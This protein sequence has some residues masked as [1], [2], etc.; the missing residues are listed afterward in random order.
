MLGVLPSSAAAPSYCKIQ[1]Q[2][3]V[4]RNACQTL[5]SLVRSLNQSG[6]KQQVASSKSKTL[7]WN[8]ESGQKIQRSSESS[9]LY[10]TYIHILPGKPQSR[11]RTRSHRGSRLAWTAASLHLAAAAAAASA[12]PRRRGGGDADA[13]DASP[14]RSLT[15]S[16]SWSSSSSS[17]KSPRSIRV[18]TILGEENENLGQRDDH[19]LAGRS[20]RAIEKDTILFYSQM[21]LVGTSS[22]S[23]RWSF[24]RNF[25]SS[26]DW[27]L[28]LPAV[29]NSEPQGKN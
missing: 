6:S 10:Y 8:P 7:H 20:N 21:C 23:D 24:S 14:L 18:S 27:F 15:S 22:H 29:G 25:R 5:S 4:F 26:A 11:L 16:C 2:K 19:H 17:S 1:N 12:M 9:L 13:E 3:P 28:A